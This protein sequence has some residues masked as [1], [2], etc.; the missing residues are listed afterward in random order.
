MTIRQAVQPLRPSHWLVPNWYRPRYRKGW[1]AGF[2]KGLTAGRLQAMH[3]AI[4]Q[5]RSQAT[6]SE[7]NAFQLG[8]DAQRLGCFER[9]N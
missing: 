3:T 2:H 7:R 5:H 1:R 4:D 8:V 6:Q 9:R